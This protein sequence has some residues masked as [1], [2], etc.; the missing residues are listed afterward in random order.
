[1]AKWKRSLSMSIVLM[2]VISLLA[3]C[4]SSPKQPEPSNN[5][6]SPNTTNNSNTSNSG[7][8]ENKGDTPVTIKV[9]V[10]N[11]NRSFPEGMTPTDNPY[12][13]YVK[14]NTGLDFEFNFP[15]SETYQDTLN[16]IMA[17]GDLPDLIHTYDSS[18]VVKYINQKALQPLNDYI[19]QYGPDLK[20]LIPEEAWANVTVDGK[21]YAIPSVTEVKGNELMYVRKDWLDKLKLEVPKTL[22]DYE[23][24]MRAFVEQ[25][26]DGNNKKDTIGLI[27]QEKIFRTAPFFGA[28]GISVG[29]AQNY[30]NEW[31]VQPDG[32]LANSVTLPETK[33]VL[34]L[35]NKWFEEGLIDPEFALNKQANMD[36]K[37]ANGRAGLFSAAWY[38]TRGAI[39]TSM[40]NDPN[41]EWIPLEYPIGPD[42]KVGT[43]GLGS[44]QSYSVVPVTS[45]NAAEVIQYLNFV[46]GEGYQ[47][48]KLG[49]EG[50]V[51]ELKDNVVVTNF[52][53]HNKHLYRSTLHQVADV[54]T[55]EV[56]TMRLDSLGLEFNLNDNVRRIEEAAIFSDFLAMP[57]P[58][59]GKH[60]AS[61]NKLIEET[62]TKMVMG[63]IPIDDFDKFVA[64]WKA[65]GG[66]EVTAEV[67][68]WYVNNK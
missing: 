60:S 37:I 41:A 18:W 25:D 24:V 55:L 44:V 35:L 7:N 40:N 30:W 8:S 34:Q 26:P 9:V 13:N 33:Q 28:H 38:E 23:N 68:E 49:F 43:G 58:A 47:N 54:N 19:D 42:G 50:E 20:K 2:L 39:L 53:E 15:P 11:S 65:S 31:Y 57:T 51:W 16:I 27:I 64:E 67:N 4:G 1:M 66:D 5:G 56:R 14:E 61:L 21:I 29:T 3:A 36:E 52:E 6:N 48:L 63:T 59:M 46:V 32:K 22:E 17:S 45:K 62:F 12:I 10:N